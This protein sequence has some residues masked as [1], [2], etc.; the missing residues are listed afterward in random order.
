VPEGDQDNE[1]VVELDDVHK[2]YRTGEMEVHAVRG[3]SLKIRSGEFVAL[4]GSSGSGKSTLMNILGCLDR[5]TRGRYLLDGQ[6]VS[7]LQRDQL[8]DFRNGKLGFVFQSFN[9]LPRTSARENVELPLLYGTHRLSNAQLREKADEVLRSV[10]LAGREDHHPS[11]LSG[12]QQQRVAIARALINDPEVLL[13]DEPTGNLDSR[14]SLEIMAIF[15][16]LNDQG[17]TVIMVTHEADIA[18][19][20]RRNVVMRDGL[21]RTDRAVQQRLIAADEVAKIAPVETEA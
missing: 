3:V 13:A 10:G 20:A 14:T 7:P 5:P 18:S 15:Q 6:D 17:I 12:G 2:I 19:F 9:L 11:Q 4:M 8:A 16:R 21:V 1:V